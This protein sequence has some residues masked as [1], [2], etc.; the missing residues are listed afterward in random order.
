MS[1]TRE[2]VLDNIAFYRAYNKEEYYHHGY[3][4]SLLM[5]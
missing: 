3:F 2:R 1:S 5:I 4:Y